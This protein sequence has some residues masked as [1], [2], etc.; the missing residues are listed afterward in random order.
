MKTS[1]VSLLTLAAGAFAGR[2]GTVGSLYERDQTITVTTLTE[3]V[4]T[5]TSSISKFHL[6]L[7]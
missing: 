3:T 1:F 7:F 2:I 5:Y 4:K 6:G